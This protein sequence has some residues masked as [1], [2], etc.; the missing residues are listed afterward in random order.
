MTSAP[1]WVSSATS[2]VLA[3][4]L[5]GGVADLRPMARTLIDKGRMRSVYRFAEGDTPASGDPVLLV[6]PL[7]APALCFDL[8][9]GCSLAEHLVDQGRSLYLVDYGTVSFSDRRLGLEHWIDE[10]LPRTIRAVSADAGGRPVHLVA[11]CLG[12]IMSLLTAADQHDLPIASIATVAAP[13]DMTA[14]PLVAPIKPLAD[15]TNGWI[16]TPAY[17]LLG[18]AP[19]ALVKRAF[20]LSA[21]DK[22]I[23][24]PYAI[25]SHLD[26]A[27]FLAQ[28]EAVD[29]FTDNM[30]AYP[31]RT[32]GQIYHRFFR[33]N[34]LAEGEVDLG[35][36]RISLAGVKIPVLVVAGVG[37][38][39]APQRAVRHLLDVLEN[40][41]EV[42]FETCPGGHLGVLTGRGART[43]TWTHLDAFLDAH[44]PL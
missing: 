11:W 39:I 33:A 13:I 16:L 36:R 9:R 3:K 40:A 18:G 25:L 42:T 19:R 32:F 7:A 26:D 2:N 35:G 15:L 28:L 43:T 22:V 27:E 23:T 24:K 37:D 12:G 34:D 14:I 41:A 20:Q 17:R 8:R 38:S 29:R 30:I 4:V 10:V 31:G 6:P 44:N 21:I 1:E 5:R